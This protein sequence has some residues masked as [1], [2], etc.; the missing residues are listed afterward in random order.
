MFSA[1]P[2]VGWV[3]TKSVNKLA[4]SGKVSLGKPCIAQSFEHMLHVEGSQWQIRQHL[5]FILKVGHSLDRHL[6]IYYITLQ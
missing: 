4:Q 6:F 5:I 3:S 1:Q 2:E